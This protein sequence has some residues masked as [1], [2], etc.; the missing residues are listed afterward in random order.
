PF[1]LAGV[2]LSMAAIFPLVYAVKA[3]AGHGV[4]GTTL[5][6]GAAGAFMLIAFVV[7]QRRAAH[8]LIPFDLFR[9]RYFAMAIAG[10]ILAVSTL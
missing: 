10:T 8:P 1:D 2:A 6:V 4:D 5:A 3:A 7:Q 9:N